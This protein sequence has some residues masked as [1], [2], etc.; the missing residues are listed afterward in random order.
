MDF[1]AMQN[2]VLSD[3]FSE[4]KRTDAK[5][6]INSR[7]GRLWA[8]EAWSFKLGFV[9]FTLSANAD[10]VSLGTLQRV[11]SFKDI[12]YLPTYSHIGAVR[13]EDYMDWRSGTSGVPGEF[14][15]VNDTIYLA[16]PAGAERTY[17]AMGEL[18]FVRLV[19]DADEPLVPEEFHEIICY[20][21]MSEGL[22]L[23]NDPSW[24]ASEQD[25]QAGIQ[26]M[27]KSYLSQ[28]L[29]PEDISPSW[30]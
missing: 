23:E 12:S 4:A 28:V 20:G 29:I 30:P 5:R 7:Y 13:P 19:D 22:R 3:R 15:I 14:T 27:R 25:F 9:D 21:A 10:S 18:R 26:D 11:H 24:S 6:W 1:L 8:Q 16:R 2:Y 17:R